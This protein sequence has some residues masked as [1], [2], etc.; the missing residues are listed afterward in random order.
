MQPAEL[1]IAR[2]GEA[3][4]N[5]NQIVGGPKGCKGLTDRGRRQ[6]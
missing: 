3:H 4:C 1:L 6:I 5:R 2:H